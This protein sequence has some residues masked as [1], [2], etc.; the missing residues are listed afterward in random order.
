MSKVRQFLL[1]LVNDDHVAVASLVRHCGAAALLVHSGET[2]ALHAFHDEY[3]EAH[4]H[5]DDGPVHHNDSDASL[6]HAS[7]NSAYGLFFTPLH[8]LVT[9]LGS[10]SFEL[11]ESFA[12]P[13]FLDGPD[14]P[15][16]ALG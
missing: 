1:L 10:P 5:H 11:Q 4:H 14:R 16:R 13:P 12:G 15:P 7:G 8:S 3:V 2:D 9:P 6:Q